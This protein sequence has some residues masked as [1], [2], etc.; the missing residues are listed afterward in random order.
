MAWKKS[1]VAFKFLARSSSDSVKAEIGASIES[2][3]NMAG[4]KV[5]FSGEY[6]GW[7]PNPDSE[8]IK[9]MCGIYR[10]LFN[11]E[12]TV[13]VVHAGLECSMIL[14]KYPGLDIC[15][16]GPTLRSPHTQ[17]ERCLIPTVPMF[18]DL[19]VKTLEEIPVK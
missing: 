14:N 19:L 17:N 12:P 4:M 5:V 7:D 11:K 13:Q 10:K 2:C 16:F 1:S 15:S 9:E 18:W 3:L 6:G 8:L